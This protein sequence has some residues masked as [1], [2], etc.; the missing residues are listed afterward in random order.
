MARC[1]RPLFLNGNSY[2]CGSCLNCRINY[3]SKWQLRLLYELNSWSGA[4]FV[5]LTYD[6]EHIPK[7]YELKKIHLRNFLK[8]VRSK[9]KYNNICLWSD[10][11]IVGNS[12]NTYSPIFRYYCAGEYGMHP[13]DGIKGHERP[14]FHCILFGVDYYNP[15]HRQ[16]IIDSWKYCDPNQFDISRGVKC[17]LQPVNIDTIGYVTGYV[18]KK[19]TGDKAVQAYGNR[20]RPFNICS[21]GLGLQL[22][23]RQ[24]DLLSK[25]YTYTHNGKRVGLPRYFREK[26]GFE[27]DYST[28]DS[29]KVI[30]DSFDY[31]NGLYKKQ[32][33]DLLSTPEAEEKRFQRWYDSNNWTVSEKIMEAFNKRNSLLN[34][35]L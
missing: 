18:R 33:P 3:T 25:G 6:D 15:N 28:S 17:A 27:I 21:H 7:N 20:K 2:N 13:R 24:K 22:A 29:Q 34:K 11:P 14:H 1:L 19:I 12:G 26:L 35:E 4:T 31:I 9:L 10:F 8:R 5:T 32:F 16:I 23:L 30:K